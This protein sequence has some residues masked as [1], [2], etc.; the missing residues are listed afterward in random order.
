M[1]TEG[2]GCVI[3]GSA[4]P[5]GSQPCERSTCEYHTIYEVLTQQTTHH[6]ECA[7]QC[8]GGSLGFL[9]PHSCPVGKMIS[10]HPFYW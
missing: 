4:V 3:K 2:S 8:A 10:M 7:G 6:P 5:W 9:S 1:S